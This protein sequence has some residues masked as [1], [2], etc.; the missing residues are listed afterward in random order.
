MPRYLRI[1]NRERQRG[2]IPPLQVHIH[3]VAA[4]WQHRR[5]VESSCGGAFLVVDVYPECRLVGRPAVTLADRVGR[6][7]IVDVVQE[8]LPPDLHPAA[9]VTEVPAS[10]YAG[11]WAGQR[12]FM[13]GALVAV[14]ICRAARPHIIKRQRDGGSRRWGCEGWGYEDGIYGGERGIRAG[15]QQG[16]GRRFGRQA[17]LH[18]FLGG[19]RSSRLRGSALAGSAGAACPPA[20]RFA[21]DSAGLDAL[22][23]EVPQPE[24]YQAGQ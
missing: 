7:P 12:A 11:Q 20:L 23:Q 3:T 18:V 6:R 13:D 16:G 17:R 2:D 10:V 4:R 5:I 1:H 15:R 24:Q 9:Q 22:Q 14:E 19:V 8:P 21:G